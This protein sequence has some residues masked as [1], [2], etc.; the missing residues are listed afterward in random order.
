M[1]KQGEYRILSDGSKSFSGDDGSKVVVYH[2]LFMFTIDE[3]ISWV[4]VYEL[5]LVK[6]TGSNLLPSW[7]DVKSVSGVLKTEH[8]DMVDS[9]E[10]FLQIRDAFIANIDLYLSQLE[11]RVIRISTMSEFVN[12]GLGEPLPVVKLEA[13]DYFATELLALIDELF[14]DDLNKPNFVKTLLD[15]I[16]KTQ[17]G[18]HLRDQI[19][20]NFKGKNIAT[21]SHKKPNHNRIA[22]LILAIAN[23]EWH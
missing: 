19:V 11:P 21:V 2:K 17:K 10:E 4:Y 1:S 3:G 13:T 14:L 5:D 9:T 23:T 22:D 7:I 8:E 12:M 18:A 6:K 15:G 20:S 16:S